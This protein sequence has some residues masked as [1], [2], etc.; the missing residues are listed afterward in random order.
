LKRQSLKIIWQALLMNSLYIIDSNAVLR[1]LLKDNLVQCEKV[2]NTLDEAKKS[3]KQVFVTREVVMECVYTLTRFY[4]VSRIDIFSAL[5]SFFDT[6]EIVLEN[7]E[8]VMKTLEYFL[9]TNISY[10]DCLVLEQSKRLGGELVT[11]DKKLLAK[12]K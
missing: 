10:V 3:G 9:M 7:R 2:K 5:K 8:L 12:S 11:F 1:Y 6:S 4:K